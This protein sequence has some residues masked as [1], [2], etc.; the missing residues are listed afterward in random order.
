MKLLIFDTETT[1]LPKSREQAIKGPNNWPHIVAI[2]WTVIDSDNDYAT[3][4]SESYIIKPEWNIPAE[5]SAIHGISEA[6]ALAEGV[7]LSTVIGKFLAVQHDIMVA[8]NIEFDYNVL[9]N[10]IVW[11]LKLG[12]PTMKRRFC[13]MEIMKNV[14]KIPFANGRGYKPPKL[15]ELYE[16]VMNKPAITANL[17]NAQYDTQLLAEIV[18]NSNYI[19]G[20][21][22]LSTTDDITSN[23]SKK[24]RTLII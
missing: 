23:A 15:S 16:H 6:K 11:D 10:A 14:L 5:S 18:K 22:G 13:T 2:A 7:P 19:R 12:F 8:H 9:I 1:G 21:M 3:V 20:V 17:H 4:S 24:A